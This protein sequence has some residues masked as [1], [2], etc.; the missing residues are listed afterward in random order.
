LVEDAKP[1]KVFVDLGGNRERF[2]V[3]RLIDKLLAFPHPP[4]LIIIKNEELFHAMSRAGVPPGQLAPSAVWAGLPR[5]P[6]LLEI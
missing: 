1:N 3:T 6:P 4:T 2:V 5:Y